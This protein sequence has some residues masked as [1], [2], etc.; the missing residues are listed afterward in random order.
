MLEINPLNFSPQCPVSNGRSLCRGLRAGC[1]MRYKSSHFRVG[2]RL[3]GQDV[4][5]LVLQIKRVEGLLCSS[6]ARCLGA[7]GVNR[8]TF[9]T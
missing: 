9:V 8:G 1:R 3:E 4:Q 6:P 2:W 7:H 5:A